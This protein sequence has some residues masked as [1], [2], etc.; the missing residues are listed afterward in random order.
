MEILFSEKDLYLWCEFYKIEEC[1]KS[2]RDIASFLYRN[3]SKP[4][5]YQPLDMQYNL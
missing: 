1:N 3:M 2:T 5:N 4:Q